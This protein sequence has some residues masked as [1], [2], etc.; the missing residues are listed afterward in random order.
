MNTYRAVN[1]ALR[2]DTSV[3]RVCIKDLCYHLLLNTGTSGK[4][5]R[6]IIILDNIICLSFLHKLPNNSLV[7]AGK[8]TCTCL[9]YVAC[10]FAYSM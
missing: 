8:Y 7:W 9:N 1:P 10:L 6:L 3:Q 5:E 4:P 2:A